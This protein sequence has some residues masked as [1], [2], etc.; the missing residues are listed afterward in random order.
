MFTWKLRICF[1]RSSL[2]GRHIDVSY[3]FND[4]DI[5]FFCEIIQN[6]PGIQFGFEIAIDSECTCDFTKFYNEY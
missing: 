3:M 1:S 2:H 4:T 6:I 5:N